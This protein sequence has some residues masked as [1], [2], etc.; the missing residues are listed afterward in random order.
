MNKKWLKV[1]AGVVALVLVGALL[2]FTNAFVGNPVSKMIATNA[3]KKYIANQY[4]DQN[5]MIEDTFFSFKDN[6]YHVK[7]KSNVSIDTHFE[8][9][10]SGWGDIRYDEYE[11]NVKDKFA[12]YVRLSDAASKDLEPKV[13]QAVPLDY[14]WVS[15]Q[16]GK[17]SY[18]PAALE[19][20][21]PY[22]AKTL[23]FPIEIIVNAF[24][25]DP[26][27][28][29]VA[30][31]LYALDAFS[32]KEELNVSAYTVY[33]RKSKDEKDQFDNQ[34]GVSGFPRERISEKNLPD[35]LKKYAEQMDKE[36]VK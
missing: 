3:A 27:W 6:K 20:D 31:I 8:V 35:V 24:E 30:E 12:T 5:L 17:D 22:N 7:V 36:V 29:K 13:K 33:L 21:M 32:T 19:L 10:V 16:M 18:N 9:Q 1:V 4:P 34:I 11:S 25:P 28:D 23:P 2:F 26:S 14:D 15:V